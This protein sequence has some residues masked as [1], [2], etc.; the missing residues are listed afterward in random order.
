MKQ[1]ENESKMSEEVIA[2]RAV[3]LNPTSEL[4]W[5]ARGFSERPKDWEEK[6]IEIK[7]EIA[8]NPAKSKQIT[9]N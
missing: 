2:D 3:K 5:K 9:K 7:K 8:E 6:L 1:N 4:Y